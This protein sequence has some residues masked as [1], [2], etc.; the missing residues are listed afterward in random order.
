MKSFSLGAL[1]VV[2]I[3]G[4]AV[5][6]TAIGTPDHRVPPP[7]PARAAASPSSVAGGG[8]ALVSTAVAMPIDEARF[9]GGAAADAINANCTAC[10]STSMVLNQP[11]LTAAQWQATITKMR[12][13]YHADIEDRD[14]PAILGYLTAIDPAPKVASR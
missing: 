4:A 1:C 9:A 13:V 7:P 2:V 5:M 8:F 12:E 11:P 3:G 6:L 10:H 14:V